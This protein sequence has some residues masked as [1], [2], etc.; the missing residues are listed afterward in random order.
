M[1]LIAFDIWGDY[2]YFRNGYTST[3]TMSFPF[4]S[5]TTI[6]GLIAG[7]LGL[8]KDSYYDLF[9]K[10]NSKIGLR[11]LNPVKKIEYNFKHINTK[12]GFILSDINPNKKNNSLHTQVNSELIKNPFYRIYVNINDDELME[13]LFQ[14]LQEHKAVYTPCFGSSEFLA[15][16]R[17]AYPEILN[18]NKQ[19]TMDTLIDSVMVRENCELIIE[20]KKNY[21]SIKMP[22]YYNNEKIIT[23]YYTLV[24]ESQGNPIR[25]RNGDYYKVGDENIIL[26]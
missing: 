5:R 18:V 26:Y 11:L 21:N 2:G 7:I 14:L 13:E 24:Y 3:S 8:P 16:F 4:P 15:N 12:C 22:A 17:L 1:K 23:A 9:S 20:P 6:T 25:I 10:D 19:Y